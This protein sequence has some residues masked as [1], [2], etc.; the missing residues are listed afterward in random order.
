M[1]DFR[2]YLIASCLLVL[3]MLFAGCTGGGN[4]G[5][6]PSPTMGGGTAP[7]LVITSPANGAVLPAGDITVSVKVSNFR[8]VPSYGQPAVAGEGHFHYYMDLPVPL[9]EKKV[10]VTPPGSFVPTTDTSH[11]FT[12]VPAGTHNFSVELA[13]NDHSPFPQPIFATV[14]VTV[15]GQLPVTTGTTVGGQPD[16]QACTTDSDCVPNLCCH[17]TNCINRAYKGVCTELCTNVCSGPIDCGAG[18]CACVKGRCGVSPGRA[19]G[20]M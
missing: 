1:P 6:T 15:T 11:T 4:Q 5:A 19:P 14:T 17:P 9:V 2:T 3:C 18:H 12:N 20:T 7:G 10:G 13:T 8:L 16:L